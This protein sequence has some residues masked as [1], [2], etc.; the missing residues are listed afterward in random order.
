M[1]QFTYSLQI[2][3]SS[4]STGT[5]TDIPSQRHGHAKHV[6]E[7]QFINASLY[8][9]FRIDT[10]TQRNI[11]C[12]FFLR[13]DNPLCPLSDPTMYTFERNL[14]INRPLQFMQ[15]G[16]SKINLFLSH[17]AVLKISSKVNDLC[18]WVFSFT[19]LI[20]NT[21]AN[22]EHHLSMT[23][24]MSP[25]LHAV[26]HTHTHMQ[27]L[28]HTDTQSPLS[29]SLLD[30]LISFERNNCSGRHLNMEVFQ[31]LAMS[32]YRQNMPHRD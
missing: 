4:L 12:L 1:K 29:L 19:Y 32:G 2:L 6:P 5:K 17:I 14:F 20:G 23:S 15:K 10:L 27:I 13:R 9:H 31:L 16:L 18:K 8:C 26:T 3:S 7:K 21:L 28:M 22:F 11:H 30:I 25:S 24:S